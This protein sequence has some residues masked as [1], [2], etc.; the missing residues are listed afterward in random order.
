ML[1]SMQGITWGYFVTTQHIALY[2]VYIIFGI[3]LCYTNRFVKQT[4]EI[5][6]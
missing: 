3:L 6:Y 5:E 4:N 2:G 1:T